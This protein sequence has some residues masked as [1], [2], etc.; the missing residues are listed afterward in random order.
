MK[1]SPD[2]KR[3]TQNMLPGV[4]TADGFLGDDTRPLPDIILADEQAMQALG[5]FFSEAADRM[6][7]LLAEG[8][9]GLGEPITF[10]H[11]WVIRVDEARGRLPCPFQDGI[12]RK[13]N[14]EIENLDNKLSLIYSE[15]SIHL[16]E[17]HHFLQG[18]G[19]PFRIEPE[20][21]KKVLNL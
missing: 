12:F 17:V 2:Y 1:V 3:A 4:I 10:E 14:A 21:L 9:K 18:K 6:K 11:R 8:R 19:S 7:K 15:L 16:L 13:V 20:M 5:L